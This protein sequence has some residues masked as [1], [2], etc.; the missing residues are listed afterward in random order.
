[1]IGILNFANSVLTGILSR[2]QEIAVLQ[3]IGMTRGQVREMLLWESG[4]YLLISAVISILAGSLG[5]YVIVG[6]LNQVVLC[7]AYRYTPLPFLI[8][9]P[10]FAVLAA[11]ISLA[12]YSQTQKKSMV[13]RLRED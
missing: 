3:S 10:V 8:M 12:A 4:Y 2:K 11:G 1:M 6:A 13:E 9:L 7:F 5:A